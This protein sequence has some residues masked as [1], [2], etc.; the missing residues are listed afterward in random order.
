[1]TRESRRA[2]IAIEI[3]RGDGCLRSAEILLRAGE[4][5]DCVGRAYY[6]A[7][8][9]ARALL[10]TLGEEPTTHSGVERLLH[11]D[12]VRPGTIDPE[13]ARLFAKLQ[14]MRLE[15]DYTSEFVFTAAGATEELASARAFVQAA[16]DVLIAGAWI[17]G[18]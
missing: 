16:R 11:R 8:H 2:N 18:E 17:T 14:K 15:S 1:L 9:Y 3:A 10:L 6:G 13:L 12:L 5:A 4:H 7:F